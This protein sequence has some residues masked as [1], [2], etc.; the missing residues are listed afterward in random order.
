[1]PKIVVNEECV[2]LVGN[3]AEP[4]GRTL[5][6]RMHEAANCGGHP[7]RKGGIAVKVDVKL[8]TLWQQPLDGRQRCLCASRDRRHYDGNAPRHGSAFPAEKLHVARLTINEIVDA[9][10]VLLAL[11]AV[12]LGWDSHVGDK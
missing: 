10:R 9:Q 1:M 2:L 6:L 12:H 5:R 8:V 3:H 4:H 11:L 7:G